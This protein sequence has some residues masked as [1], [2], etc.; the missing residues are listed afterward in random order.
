MASRRKKT[1]SE[2]DGL[3]QEDIDKALDS[4]YRILGIIPGKI[5]PK[6]WSKAEDDGKWLTFQTIPYPESPIP[7]IRDGEPIKIKTVFHAIELKIEDQF[8]GVFECE[9]YMRKTA[10]HIADGLSK[11]Y[12]R[13]SK[14]EL[15]KAAREN[16]RTYEEAKTAAAQFIAERI[17]EIRGTV[18]KFFHDHL[19]STLKVVLSDLIIDAELCGME[20]YGYKLATVAEYDQTL[21]AYTQL[22]RNRVDIIP[23]KGR[24]QGSTPTSWAELDRFLKQCS[25]CY[26]DLK[27][28]NKRVSKHALARKMYPNNSNASQKLTRFL[29]RY[30]ITFDQVIEECES[31]KM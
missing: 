4:L 11:V 3:T 13:I 6:T 22:R 21:R 14:A 19:E 25:V 8:G 18:A 15:E 9:Y 10:N 24:P 26:D 23:G 2:N 31:R 20:R 29:N 7:K 28:N 5:K 30:Q 27:I 17:F 12:P 16:G 1:S